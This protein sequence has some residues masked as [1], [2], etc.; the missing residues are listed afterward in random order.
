MNKE[1]VLVNRQALSK[2]SVQEMAEVYVNQW[3]SA[4]QILDEF[5]TALIHKMQKGHK[6]IVVVGEEVLT[7]DKVITWKKDI[8]LLKKAQEMLRKKGEKVEFVKEVTKEKAVDKR[9][10][11]R[12]IGLGGP[13][14]KVIAKALKKQVGL[15]KLTIGDKEGV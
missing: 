8:E 1:M 10:L 5:E 3:G 14:A 9:I 13:V 11:S 6:K 12:Y 15:P 2:M 4:H 7:L